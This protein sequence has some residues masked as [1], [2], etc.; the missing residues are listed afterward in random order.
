MTPAA[1]ASQPLSPSF[2]SENRKMNRLPR[3]FKQKTDPGRGLSLNF[4][5][6]ESVWPWLGGSGGWV[7]SERREVAGSSP[8]RGT[9]VRS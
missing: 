2:L 9:R 5:K 8:G 6:D 1:V 7:P 3:T 4:Y